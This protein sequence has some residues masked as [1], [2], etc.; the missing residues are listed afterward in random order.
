M[1]TSG[2]FH[3]FTLDDGGNLWGFGSTAF[4]KLG[5]EGHSLKIPTKL[6][7]LPEISFVSC[8]GDSTA[9][10]DTE[11]NLWTFGLE[12]DGRLGRDSE[13]SSEILRKVSNLPQI[14]AVY[15]GQSHTICLANDG[16]T[17]GFG[18]NKNLQLGLPQK[19]IYL[20]T[21]IDNI[22]DV[23]QVA[24][25]NQYTTILLQNGDVMSTG[26][27]NHGTLGLGE[28]MET[29]EFTK[30]H[31]LNPNIISIAGGFSH[32]LFLDSDGFVFGVGQNKDNQLGMPD[33]N[34]VF[35]PQKIED[36]CFIKLISCG[37]QHSMCV[38]DN[39]S[40]ITFGNNAYGQ[41][42]RTLG[43]I[44]G[45]VDNLANIFLLSS[46]GNRTI[47]KSRDDIVW[48][49]GDNSFGS[50]GVGDITNRDFPAELTPSTVVGDGIS[51][52]NCKSARN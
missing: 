7:N 21:C 3:T 5:L 44:I 51:F 32:C 22:V 16:T 29:S 20:P 28:K 45:K 18:S 2:Y 41:L 12:T 17:W 13:K 4:N 24:C 37:Y 39:G 31:D 23:M 26:T 52:T 6:S 48:S 19:R 25:G 34:N 42:G 46:G 33:L 1:I 27:C 36:L 38:D 10:V 40:L 9:C 8:S 47:A 43:P 30:I 11:G 50:L 35:T 15:C 14:C 49:F